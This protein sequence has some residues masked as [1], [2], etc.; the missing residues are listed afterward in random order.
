MDVAMVQIFSL[1]WGHELLKFGA[2]IHDSFLFFMAG[3]FPSEMIVSWPTALKLTSLDVNSAFRLKPTTLTLS[4]HHM[5]QIV[6]TTTWWCM[7]AP[8]TWLVMWH[9]QDMTVEHAHQDAL[10][11]Q[12]MHAVTHHVIRTHVHRTLHTATHAHGL[13]HAVALEHV[14]MV[15]CMTAAVAMNIAS[16]DSSLLAHF[17][18]FATAQILQKS[19]IWIQPWHWELQTAQHCTSSAKP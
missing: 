7:C 6:Q 9:R 4:P 8:S 17:T 18:C 11:H 14:H 15:S 16:H 1:H 19:T 2:D 12:K 13:L 5:D 3:F 10:W